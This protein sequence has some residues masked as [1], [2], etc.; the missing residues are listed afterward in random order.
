MLEGELGQLT[1]IFAPLRRIGLTLKHPPD[2]AALQLAHQLGENIEH[3]GARLSLSVPREDVPARVNQLLA[4]LPVLDLSV[5]EV[6]IESVIR[7]MF[8]QGAPT[9]GA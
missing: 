7:Q 1:Q 9:E 8:S 2:V 4:Q 3:E 5:A 6:E